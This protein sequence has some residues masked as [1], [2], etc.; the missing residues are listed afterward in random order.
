[1][2]A[3]LLA[4]QLF[5]LVFIAVFGAVLVNF[6][7]PN[8]L[9]WM[10]DWSVRIENQAL[11]LGLRIADV[12]QAHRIVEKGIHFI[13]DARKEEIYAKA[14]LPTALSLPSSSFDEKFQEVADMLIPEQ[15]IMVYCSGVVCD[16]SLQVCQSLLAQGYTNL[17]LFSS[18]FDA[19]TAAGHSTEMGL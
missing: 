1:M 12:E 7:R 10:E 4:N 6:L 18:G 17:I 8:S 14:H 2:R 5:F 19:W 16:E 3:I 15:E 11:E 13:F 9:P